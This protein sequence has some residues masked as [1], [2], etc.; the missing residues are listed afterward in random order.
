MFRIPS[1]L[2]FVCIATLATVGCGGSSD[3]DAGRGDAPGGS[4][5]FTC[6]T[7]ACTTARQY[8][9]ESMSTASGSL[10]SSFSCQALPASCSGADFCASP[11]FTGMAGYQGCGV[12]DFG[13]GKEYRVQIM[14]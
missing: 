5:T 8:C 14:R 13:S 3:T 6:G 2:F 12:S 10:V 7:A 4:G 1:T 9:E 11:C